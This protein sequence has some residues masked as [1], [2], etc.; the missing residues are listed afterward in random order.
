M[1]LCW[2]EDMKERKQVNKKLYQKNKKSESHLVMSDSFDPMAYIAHG[3]LQARLEWEAVPF[4]RGSSQPRDQT[5]VSHIVG[6]FFTSSA[7]REEVH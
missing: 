1:T 6:G 5:Q 2:L 3:T 4:S 7:T